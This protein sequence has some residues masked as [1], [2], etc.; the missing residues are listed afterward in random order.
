[1]LIGQDLDAIDVGAELLG[2]LVT[3]GLQLWGCAAVVQLHM[4]DL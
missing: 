3:H 2:E 1:M 4:K